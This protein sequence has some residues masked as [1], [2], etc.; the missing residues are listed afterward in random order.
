MN[1]FRK[2]LKRKI[3]LCFIIAAVLGGGYLIYKKTHVAVAPTQYVTAPVT[4]DT[5]IVS[6]SG[7]G[8]V[9][10]SNQ[11]ELKPQ[12]SGT[13]SSV[14]VSDGQNIKAG[15]VIARLDAT[16]A[17]KAVRDAQVN[18]DSAKLSLQKLVQPADQLSI[19][20]SEN[21]LAR[22]EDAKKTA[23]DDLNKAYDGGFSSVS[24]AFLDLPNVMN[25]LHDLLYTSDSRLGGANSQWNIDFYSSSAAK[26]DDRA[27]DFKANTDQKF[28][29]AQ[30]AYNKN[31]TD[32]KVTS[33]SSDKATIEA[34]ISQTYDTSKIM[35]EAVKSAYNLIQFY[36]DKLN[37]KNLTPSSLANTHI[38]TLNSYTAKTNSMLTS[39]LSAKTTIQNDKDS[40]TAAERTILENTQSLEKLKAGA[41]PLDIQFAELTLKQRENALLDA[42][43]T[44]SD[45]TVLA[46]F[47]GAVVNITSKV[48]DNASSG[49]A[50]ATLVG[51]QTLVQISLNEVDVAK[52]KVGQKATMTF[53]AIEGL[54]ISGKVVEV[55]PLGTVSQGVVSYAV[56]I[57]FDTQD[58]RIK[59]GMSVTAAIVTDVRPD[60]LVAPN[61][62]VKT[63]GG[64]RYVQVLENGSPKNLSVQVGAS[65]DTE[66][67]IASGLS[68]GQEIIT[69]TIQAAAAKITTQT[70]G[71]SLLPIGGGGGFRIGGG[72]GR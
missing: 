26:Y 24:N 63:Q 31:F 16:N 41:D 17:L 12:V 70:G 4:K 64:N 14:Y 37:E 6:V 56:K 67:E 62:A 29:A 51:S 22:A 15:T 68:E 9:Q 28:L 23:E 42:E 53:D 65:N 59:P 32:F 45:Y 36:I 69:Q 48:G 33:R 46:P 3:L 50:M 2:L 55:N 35:A 40:I 34:L 71:N 47:D 60:V 39:L 72:G 49:T 18:L 54:S 11:I 44:L 10:S 66:T 21:A 20:Q 8:Q 19:T 7:T 13:V 30:S 43:A 5:L 52:I 38:S 25:G 61:A 1:F 27:A 57:V 58:D